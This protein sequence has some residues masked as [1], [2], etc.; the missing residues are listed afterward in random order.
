VI[1]ERRED[2][3]SRRERRLDE[4]GLIVDKRLPLADFFKMKLALIGVAFFSV[5]T[6]H[7]A[8]APSSLLNNASPLTQEE[9]L[10]KCFPIEMGAAKLD[11][12]SCKVSGIEELGSVDGTDFAIARYEYF[13]SPENGGK[14]CA[15][16]SVLLK[17]LPKSTS[18][19]PLWGSLSDLSPADS[20]SPKI[21]K[22]KAR[23]L[24]QIPIRAE[25]TGAAQNDGILVWKDGK[26]HEINALSYEAELE[27]HLPPGLGVNKGIYP[28]YEKMT[29]ETGVWKK[30]DPN[31]CPSG[32]KL[33][34]KLSLKN[35]RV[36]I[37]SYQ[38]KPDEI[39]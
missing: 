24:I 36:V 4:T 29:V 2:E 35:D 32:G 31:C 19:Q 14:N 12:V 21:I 26:L 13:W 39:Q 20:G 17:R 33:S 6:A 15:Y 5:V 1:R 10:S 37:D 34:A 38:F 16:G 23:T 30:D 3:I 11:C 28:D 27:S 25:G 8:S 18:V 22:T 9:A 7:A